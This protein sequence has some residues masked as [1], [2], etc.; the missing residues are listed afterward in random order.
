METPQKKW[1][2]EKLLKI[3]QELDKHKGALPH[4]GASS[5]SCK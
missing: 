2:E 3:I 1:S 4:S 5:G